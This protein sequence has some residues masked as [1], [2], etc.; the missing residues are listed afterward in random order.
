MSRRHYLAIGLLAGVTIFC[1]IALTRLFS[2]V[3]YYHGAFLAISVALFGFA[4]SGVFVML[5]GERMGRERLDATLARYGLLFAAAIPLSFYT[6]LYAGVAPALASAGAPG[7]LAAAAEYALLAL[8]FFASGVCISM[9]LTHGAA[10]ANRLY[11]A[12]LVCSALGAVAVIPALSLL[13]GP[14]SMLAASALAAAA[15]LPFGYATRATRFLAPAAVLAALACLVMIPPSAFD[16]WRLRKPDSVVATEQIRWNAFSMVGVGPLT[17]GGATRSIIID[18]S[19][20]TAMTRF[21]GR[22]FDRLPYLRRDFAAAAYRLEPEAR[23]LV[24]GSG[25]GRDILVALSNGAQHVRAVEVNPLVYRTAAELFGDFTGGVYAL[26]GV[27]P[28]IGDA[29]SYIANSHE[30]FDVILASLIDTWAA[31][32]AGAFALT[33]NLL[34]TTDA[35]RDYYAHLADDGILSVSRWHPFETPRLISTAFTAWEEAGVQD[36]RRHAV[37]LRTPPPRDFGNQIV[38]LLL[39]KSPFTPDELRTLELFAA[40][41]RLSIGLSP[42]YVED[43]IVIEYFAK[44]GGSAQWEGLDLSAAT[45]ERPFFFNMLLPSTQALRMLG[46]RQPSPIETIAFEGNLSATRVLIQLLCAVVLLL[47]ALVA[48]PL[49]L[50]AGTVRRPGWGAILG[51][52]ACLGLGFILIEVG[53]LQRLILL[54]GQPVYALAAILSTM[55]LA[56][57]LGSF[58]SARI[59]AGRIGPRIA[60][61]LAGATVLLVA[62]AFWLPDVIDALLGRPFPVRLGA[63]VALVAVP[64][65]LLGMPFPS[66]LRALEHVGARALVPWVWGINGAMS[67][68]ASVSAIVLALEFGYTAVFGV[69]AACYGLAALLVRRWAAAAAA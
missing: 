44:K 53:L 43:P 14:R 47:S 61:L 54:L 9:L 30:R 39:K 37:L 11:A 60:A 63:A 46:L 48:A 4:V 57:G 5:R 40:E 69:G 1:E 3:Q 67:V 35:F 45:D 62:Y 66:G 23:A 42:S 28:V 19:V 36:V 65:F 49:L 2:V 22:S 16:S 21:D 13:G 6:Y 15:S 51:Y 68:M 41:A 59:G 29:R 58:A 64:G 17:D 56:S 34:Y 12:D 33:E 25:G 20:S 55:L 24:I 50:R 52:F 38:T 26:P 10:D 27:Q 18:N 31:S 32:S 7:V 8:P